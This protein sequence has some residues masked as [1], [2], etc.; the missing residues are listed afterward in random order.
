MTE[1]ITRVGE[2]TYHPWKQ[3]SR[4]SLEYSAQEMNLPDEFVSQLSDEELFN[5]VLNVSC[6]K[7][8]E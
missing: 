2:D 7:S 6:S 8:V 4:K 1:Y 5:V 3:Y